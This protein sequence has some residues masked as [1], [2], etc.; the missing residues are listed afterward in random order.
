[1]RSHIGLL[2]TVLAV[3]LTNFNKIND[4]Y[5]NDPRDLL[6]IT[7]YDQDQATL[8]ANSEWLET[9]YDNSKMSFF[10]DNMLNINNTVVIN[11]ASA[12]SHVDDTPYCWVI[13]AYHSTL[14]HALY[15]EL[16]EFG[17]GISEYYY[18]RCGVGLLDLAYPSNRASFSK[19]VF[20][21]S[22]CILLRYPEKTRLMFKFDQIVHP[23]IG[24]PMHAVEEWG[25]IYGAEDLVKQPVEI[26]REIDEI[27]EEM[28]KNY[29][30]SSIYM[31]HY[32]FKKPSMQYI[33]D[34]NIQTLNNQIHRKAAE[35]VAEEK[36][37]GEEDEEERDYGEIED[38]MKKVMTEKFKETDLETYLQDQFDFYVQH[39]KISFEAGLTGE[40]VVFKPRD[41]PAV[42]DVLSSWLEV[43]VEPEETETKL[44]EEL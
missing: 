30:I 23:S 7:D 22:P 2:S 37:L 42:E 27:Y 41:P 25:K 26:F 3:K 39:S 40:K 31:E 14:D 19:D 28:H 16:L 21:Q 13:F 4:L 6:G 32:S 15:K 1:M 20:K 18:E 10:I 33:T 11:P 5:P 9:V 17:K 34:M 36:K 29:K 38:E 24:F 43:M 12:L 44:N 8:Q 35:F